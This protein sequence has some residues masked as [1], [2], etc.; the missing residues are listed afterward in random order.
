MMALMVESFTNLSKALSDK[1]TD[2]KSE[3]PK[4]A[5]DPKKFCPWYLAIITQLSL[6]PWQEFYDRSTNN[7]VQITNNATLNGKLYSKILLALE[8]TALQNM[9]SR[10]HL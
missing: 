8:G 5:G 4:F 6:P 1:S 2:S 9:V 7:I 10:K 3:W